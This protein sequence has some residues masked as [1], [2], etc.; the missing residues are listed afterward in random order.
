[1]ANPVKIPARVR[2]VTRHSEKVASFEFEPLGRVPRFQPGQFLHLALDEYRMGSPWPDS[3]VFSIASAPSERKE[4]LAITV[5]AKGPFTERILDELGEGEGCWLK[6]PYGDFTFGHHEH[7]TLIAGGVGITPYVSL[8][9]TLLEQRSNQAVTLY[10]G[11]RQ[12]ELFLFSD[13]IHACDAQ[14]EHFQTVIYCEETY[15][16]AHYGRLDIEEIVREVHSDTIYY[17]SGPLKMIRA[18]EKMLL[19]LNVSSAQIKI[20]DWGL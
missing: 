8:L 7:L 19:E 15:P 3:R 6:L 2:R 4:T 9:K 20:D 14:L 11:F 10:Y 5:S 13:L 12:S 18:F 17:L 16:A 1:M